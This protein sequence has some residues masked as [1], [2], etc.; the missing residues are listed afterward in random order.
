M[1]IRRVQRKPLL[2]FDIFQVPTTQNYQ[3]TKATHSGVTF[4]ASLQNQDLNNIHPL[5]LYDVS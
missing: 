5:G 1:Q 4:S 2:A 3:Y